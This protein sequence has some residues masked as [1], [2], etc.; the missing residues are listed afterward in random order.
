MS[1]PEGNQFWKL[2]SK[3][4]RDKIFETPDILATACEEYFEA[5]SKRVWNKIEY[6][7]SEVQMVTIPTSVPFTLSGLFIF[8]GVN[9]QYFKD[10]KKSCNKDFS[11]VIANVEQ[12]IYTQKFEGAVVGAY[13]ANI[14]A[15]D[16]GLVDKSD[17]T[18]NGENVTPII[19]IL[20]KSNDI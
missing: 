11:L 1:A 12:I 5:T 10:F 16:L 19:N 17:L 2:R 6:K 13:N 8:L 4:G 3:H 15:R 18:S 14:I 20:P 7:G 9:S